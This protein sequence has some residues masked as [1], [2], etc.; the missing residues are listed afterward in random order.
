MASPTS[1]DSR[2]REYKDI[3]TI[4]L[5]RDAVLRERILGTAKI[6]TKAQVTIPVEVRRKFKLEIGDLLIFAEEDGKLI[7]RKA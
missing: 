1:R 7:V 3:P 4:L 5:S 2:A 6:S